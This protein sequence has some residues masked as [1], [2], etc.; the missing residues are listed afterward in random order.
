MCDVN[1]DGWESG[2]DAAA[3]HHAHKPECSVAIT[4]YVRQMFN[5]NQEIDEDPMSEKYRNARLQSFQDLWPHENKR[6]WKCKSVKLAES[7]WFFDPEVDA[8]DAVSC[9]YCNL[10]IGNWE[11]KDDPL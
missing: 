2:D 9:P 5:S 10:S 7:G 6:A 1:L 8:E 4:S 11:P 3:E